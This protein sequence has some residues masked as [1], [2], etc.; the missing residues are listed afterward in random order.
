V[1]HGSVSALD[2]SRASQLSSF[3]RCINLTRCQSQGLFVIVL[4]VIR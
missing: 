2:T 3:V 1:A 4:V